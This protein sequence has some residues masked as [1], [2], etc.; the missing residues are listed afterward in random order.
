MKDWF[1][2]WFSSD[3]YLSVYAHRN[4]DDAENILKLILNSIP[5][6]KKLRILDAACGAGRHSIILAGKGYDITAFDLSKILLKIGAANA[7]ELNADVKFLCSDIR[8][9][10]FKRPFDLVL[11]MFTSFGYFENDEENFS[12]FRHTKDFLSTDGIVVLDYLNEAFLRDNLNPFSEKIID[13]KLIKESR[14]IENGRI[15]KKI[16]IE[17]EDSTHSFF[18][19]VRLYSHYEIV[20]TF[21]HLGYNVLRTYGDYLGNSYKPTTSERLI[22][23]FRL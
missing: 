12:F 21:E 9:I 13:N 4:E 2:K 20:S 1:R 8:Y 18:E 6:Q 11:N 3:E 10:T 5:K 19:T 7:K 23:F 15:I 16:V 14:V 17:G 22:L